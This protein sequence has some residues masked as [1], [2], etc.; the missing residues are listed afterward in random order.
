MKNSAQIF[1]AF[2]LVFIFS[3]ISLNSFAA[4]YPKE[5]RY[6]CTSEFDPAMRLIAYVTSPKRFYI[7]IQ[8]QELYPGI[9]MSMHL[10]AQMK[11]DNPQSP[12]AVFVAYDDKYDFYLPF[13]KSE[14]TQPTMNY[15]NANLGIKIIGTFQ[16]RTAYLL[17]AQYL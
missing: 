3:F 1:S 7:E 13:P 12:D 14:L 8:S 9:G 11:Q 17:C 5:T 16:E 15:F 6:L 10:T 2:F 4:A